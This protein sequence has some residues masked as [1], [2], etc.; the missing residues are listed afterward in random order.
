MSLQEFF[1]YNIV[2]TTSANLVI[3]STNSN[4][5]VTTL[6]AANELITNSTITNLVVNSGLNTTGG[7]ILTNKNTSGTLIFGEPNHSIYGRI[8]YDGTL[9][10]VNF[11]SFSHFR[12]YTSGLPGS[13]LMTLNSN[14]NLSLPGNGITS[15]F[16]SNTL[17]NLFTTGGNIGINST[18]PSTYAELTINGGNST[19]TSSQANIAFGFAQT[20]GFYH[21][22]NSRHN[23]AASSNQNS[24]DF[25]LNNASGATSSSAPNFGNVN[26]M[27]VTATGVGIFNSNPS[28]TLD[29]NGSTRILNST[30]NVSMY[31]SSGN[32]NYASIE[33]FTTGNSSVKIPL[34]LNAYGGTVSINSTGGAGYTLDV[35]G[36]ARIYSTNLLVSNTTANQVNISAVSNSSG[37]FLIAGNADTRSYIQYSSDLNFSRSG[38]TNPAIYIQGTTGNVGMGFNSSPLYTLDVAGATR[39]GT[40]TNF[41]LNLG[42]SG[43]GSVRA[44]YLYGDGTAASLVNQQAGPLFFATN[45]LAA[46]LIINTTGNI[47]IGT[48]FPRANLEITQ[49]SSTTGL[50]LYSGSDDAGINR[51][52]FN[53]SATNATTNAYNKVQIQTQA[54][55]TG[56]FARA[57]FAICVN[58]AGDNTNATF[59]DNKLFI[60]GTSGLIGINTT[61]PNARLFISGSDSTTNGSDAGLGII[62]TA[63]GSNNTWYIRTGATGTATPPSGLSIADNSAYRMTF[64][65]TGN[66]GIATTSPAYTLDVNGT[67]A[68]SGV[69]L[70]RFDNGSFSGVSVGVI[71]I[72]FSDS[73][74]NF[75]EVKVNYIVSA[76]SNVVLGG[77]TASNGSGSALSLSEFSEITTTH[78]AG[79]GGNI[80]TASGYI[81]QTTEQL[82]VNNQFS[83]KIVRASGTSTTGYRNHYSFDTVYCWSGTGTARV[84]GQGHI[85]SALN[86]SNQLLSILMTPSTGTISGTW[87]TQHY[88]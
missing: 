85:D 15:S 14:G 9:N 86:L 3:N 60:S 29:V 87:N 74:Y 69:R 18:G 61:N 35:N 24:I 10:T 16:N 75:V 28:T 42:N 26:S 1:N 62:N 44:A 19:L 64:T 4:V 12:W 43:V 65:S 46:S 79:T 67:I 73:T 5:N 49:T 56:Q 59:T 40:G 51:I 36:S 63:S 45:N 11:H 84:Y 23:G 80:K 6:T 33:A 70:P 71:P 55:G 68:R 37:I 39:I 58:T 20:P 53:H 88:Y 22:I 78:N 17:G 34:C 50:M 76:V 72:L 7:L 81:S 27:S 52:I 47:G 8:G 32:G 30:N 77:N 48:F 21:F 54:V 41:L 2:L 82:G 31:L 57:N 13:L 25:Y 83:I 38:G 66:I